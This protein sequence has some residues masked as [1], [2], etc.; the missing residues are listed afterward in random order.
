MNRWIKLII[1]VMTLFININIFFGQA[2]AQN[3]VSKDTNLTSEQF[4]KL[5]DLLKQ[6]DYINFFSDLKNTIISLNHYLTFLKQQAEFG[7][8]PVYWLLGDAESLAGNT[9]ESRKWFYVALITTQQDSRICLDR[10][11]RFAAQ[12]LTRIFER[13]RDYLTKNPGDEKK[14][15]KEAILYIKSI[16][17]RSHPKWACFY[18]TQPLKSGINPTEPKAQWTNIRDNVIEYFIRQMEIEN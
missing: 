9:T 11:S 5:S 3:I 8:V 16:N 14:A 6:E 10:T 12:K 18:G 4:N 2:D 13:L 1:I 15:T 17:K 7:H